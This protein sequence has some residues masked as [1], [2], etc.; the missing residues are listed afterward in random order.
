MFTI[1]GLINGTKQKIEYN[2]DDGIG[3]YNGDIL[4]DFKMRTALE[5]HAT[6]GPI[7]QYLERD[8]DEPLAAL[9]MML[10][11]FD[12]VEKIEGD[13]P[14]ATKLPDDVIG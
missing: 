2:W 13:I 10:E 5:S 7:G 3:S 11:C 4:V 6:L 9:C 1:T 14:T 8:L 12:E